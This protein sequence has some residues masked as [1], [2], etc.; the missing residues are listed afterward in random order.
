MKRIL[1][2]ISFALSAFGAMAQE[3]ESFLSDSSVI[4]ASVSLYIAD[5]NTGKV[6]IDFDSGRS[7]APASVMK[8]ITSAAALEMLGPQYYFKT[9]LGYTGSISRSGKLKGDIVITGG[10]DPAFG[11]FH[12]PDYYKDFPDGWADEIKMLGIKKIKGRVITD[13]SYYDYLPVPAKW[14]WEDLGNYYG[15]GVYGASVFDNTYEIHLNTNSDSSHLFISRIIPEQCMSELTNNLSAAGTSD[16]GYVFAAPYSTKGWIAGTI[17]ARK[18]DFILDAS[19]P[20][21]PLVIARIIND[22]LLTTGIRVTGKPTTARL[23]NGKIP[24]MINPVSIITSPPLAEIIEALNH[25]SINMYAE[26]LTKEMG[27]KFNGSGSTKAGVEVIYAF[28]DSAGV[29][30]EGMYI[31]DGSGLSPANSINSKNLV[32]LL[33]YMKNKGKY[34]AEY[35][36]SL[37]EAGKEG[38]LKNYFKDNVFDSH[39]KAKSGSM[40]RVKCYAGYLTTMAGNQL[41]FS[42]LINNFSGSSMTIVNGFEQVLKD[43]ILN[44]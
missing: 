12:F 28:L 2:I 18:D 21:P 20:D 38:T 5:A 4:H 6:I 19:I 22:K 10:G 14:L 11:S 7:L 24:K 33:I 30:T 27:R 15:A 13:D 26:H 39:L 17:P 44:K 8:L 3:C 42:L 32:N 35:F 37:P 34:F 29:G 36:N 40:K 43:L 23:E 31:E 25:E 41:V 1:F 9:A 16:Q